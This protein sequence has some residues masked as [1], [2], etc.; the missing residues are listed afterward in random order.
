MLNVVFK[1]IKHL[2]EQVDQV[3]WKVRSISQTMFIKNRYI[4]DGVVMLHETLNDLH[5]SKGSRVLFKLDS[6]KAFDKIKW[7]FLLQVLEI[8][9]F[10]VT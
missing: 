5:S 10:L 7:P 4:M 8:K 3:I 2:G 6:E 1:I 9:G